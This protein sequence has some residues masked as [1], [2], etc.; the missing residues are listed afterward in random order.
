MATA[1]NAWVR[2]PKPNPRASL[3]L[4]CFHYAGGGASAFRGWERGLPPDI[5]LL[6]VQLPGRENRAREKAFTHMAPLMDVL[7]E[8]L[9]PLFDQPFVLFGHSLGALISFEL[10]RQLRRRQGPVPRHLFVSGYRAPQRPPSPSERTIH[11]LPEA[12]FIQELRHFNG[13]PEEILQNAELMALLM[14]V[15]R[16]DFSVYETYVYEPEDPLTCDI[17]AFGGL[18]D[19]ITKREDMVDWRS[20]TRGNF[21]LRML[22][23]DHFFLHSTQAQFL[24][25]LSQDLVPILHRI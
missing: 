13:T 23:G 15:L 18:Q 11:H 3:R 16:A 5:E 7:T 10:A 14:P 12:E 2:S 1:W 24:Q 25:M 19:P 4:F 20:Q 21:T 9:S 17:S 6:L 22:P 8:V